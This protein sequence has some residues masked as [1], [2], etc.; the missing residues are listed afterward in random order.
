MDAII[1]LALF[2]QKISNDLSNEN[3]LYNIEDYIVIS[4]ICFTESTTTAPPKQAVVQPQ[5]VSVVSHTNE[6]NNNA[7]SLPTQPSQA[8]NNQKGRT[9]TDNNIV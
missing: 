2:T 9:L 7:G 3:L 8:R 6:G 5:P 4:I 1:C